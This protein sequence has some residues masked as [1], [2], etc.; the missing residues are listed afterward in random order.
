MIKDQCII[1][2]GKACEIIYD[3]IIRGGGVHSEPIEGYRIIECKSCK[4]HSLY[5][6]PENIKEFYES[7]E[8]RQHYDYTIDEQQLTQKYDTEQNDRISKI[9][10]ENLRNKIIGDFGCGIGIFLDTVKGVAKK[11]VAV[12]PM[13]L[14]KDILIR[15]G[16]VYYEY[17]QSM[18]ANSLDV[19]VTFDTLEHIDNPILYLTSI[20][21]TI[22]TGGHLYLAVPNRNDILMNT[23]MKAF[24]EFFYC[25]AH[26]FYY[27]MEAL[28]YVVEKSGFKIIERS[29]L[30]KYDFYNF[31][32]WLKEEKPC[33]RKKLSFIDPFFEKMFKNELIRLNLSSHLFIKAV[34]L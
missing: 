13:Q 7:N 19:A 17:P 3:G 32:S 24:L 25:K 21:K 9:G 14:C 12:E 34:K 10:I 6:T 30:H 16:H 4:I 2:G 29:G 18:D 22:L 23:C 26:L 20:Y 28:C 31:M 1:C 15:K 11:T 8:Y 5:P 27:N 33:G